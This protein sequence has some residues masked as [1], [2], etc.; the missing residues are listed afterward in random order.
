MV[1]ECPSGAS[2]ITGAVRLEKLRE[3]GVKLIT[4]WESWRSGGHALVGALRLQVTE[5]LREVG[6]KLRGSY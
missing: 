5:E 3:V 4:S 6:V 1:L 2:N